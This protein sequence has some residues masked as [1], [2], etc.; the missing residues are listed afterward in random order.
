MATL[1]DRKWI[2]PGE[3]IICEEFMDDIINSEEGSFY[4]PEEFEN[5]FNKWKKVKGYKFN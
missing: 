3:K 2:L 1:G 5:S 4:T